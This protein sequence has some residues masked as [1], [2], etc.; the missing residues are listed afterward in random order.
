MK[1]NELISTYLDST[2]ETVGQ[3]AKRAGVNRSTVYRAKSGD[4]HLLFHLVESMV[5]AAGGSIVIQ[6]PPA[7]TPAHC[8]TPAENHSTREV[9]A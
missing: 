8:R 4:R 6:P 5:V 1:Y 9:S 3:F 7:D 2:K